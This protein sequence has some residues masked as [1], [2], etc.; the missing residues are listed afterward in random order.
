MAEILHTEEPTQVSLQVGNLFG[1]RRSTIIT[2][3]NG[4][5]DSSSALFLVIKVRDIHFLHLRM[6][7][8]SHM[9]ADDRHLHLGF[10]CSC[11]TSLASLSTP[12]SSSCLPVAPFT[13]SELSS[14]CPENSSP[15]LCRIATH[16]GTHTHTHTPH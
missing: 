4:A 6:K 11:Y 2:L 15:T 5:F 1:S 9:S 8:T 12:P 14:C 7:T 13:C 3:Y 16:T 10:V